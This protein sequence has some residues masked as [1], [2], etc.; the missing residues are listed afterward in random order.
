MYTCKYKVPEDVPR[1]EFTYFVFTSMPGESYCR[2]LTSLL[3]YL[4][5]IVQALINSLVCWVCTGALGLV[6]FQI[7]SGSVHNTQA[8]NLSAPC[9]DSHDEGDEQTSIGRHQVS[10]GESRVWPTFVGHIAHYAVLHVR[11]DQ[12]GRGRH[13]G[14][15]GEGRFCPRCLLLCLVQ[16]RQRVK[17]VVD[18]KYHIS[19]VSKVARDILWQV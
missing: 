8:D 15:R 6:L 9:I 4:C 10:L 7:H 17:D 14:Y 12:P 19:N 5:Y 3:L 1:V 2:R 11:T 16:L 18:W 13:R